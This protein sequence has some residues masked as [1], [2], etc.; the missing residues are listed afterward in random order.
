MSTRCG[1]GHAPRAWDWQDA[2]G[3][4]LDVAEILGVEL[5]V[6]QGRHQ[7]F[8]PG[9]TAELRLAAGERAGAVVGHA[10]ELLPKWLEEHDL[11]ARTVAAELDLDALVAYFRAMA[12]RKHDPGGRR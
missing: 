11:P 12:T 5:D 9:R 6:V 10:G 7:A 3:A 1:A 2:L 4:A 8:H